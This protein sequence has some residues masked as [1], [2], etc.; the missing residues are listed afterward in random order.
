MTK[1]VRSST[2]GKSVRGAGQPSQQHKGGGSACPSHPP[3]HGGGY[4]DFCNISGGDLGAPP[5]RDPRLAELRRMGLSRTWLAVAASV[6]FDIFMIIWRSL[7]ADDALDGRNRVVVPRL[8]TYY[9]YQRNQLIR[10]LSADGMEPGD[11]RTM[12][13]RE[14]G[15]SLSI[16]HIRRQIDAA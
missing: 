7:A 13:L 4:P 11:I 12:L 9:R 2:R 3:G 14:T 5:A 15:E 6:G 1:Q 16:S 8:A 10:T